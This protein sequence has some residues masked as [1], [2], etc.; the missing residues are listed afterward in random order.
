[1]NPQP[2]DPKGGFVPQ[3]NQQVPPL[4]DPCVTRSAALS[5]LEAAATGDEIP[6]ALIDN[7]LDAVLETP[8]VRLALQAREGGPQ[9]LQLALR[10]AAACLR[11]CDAWEA[12]AGKAVG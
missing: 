4:Y 8:A 11:A 9:R 6:E 1:M 12:L 5:I 7:L 3:E 2:S 10:L